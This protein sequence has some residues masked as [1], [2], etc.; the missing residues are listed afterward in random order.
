MY[1]PNE[2]IPDTGVAV[3]GCGDIALPPALSESVMALHQP[4]TNQ[5]PARETRRQGVQH[6]ASL[7]LCGAC[8]EQVEQ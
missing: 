7:T 4:S 6:G 3:L 8:L 2:V 1:A 5:A